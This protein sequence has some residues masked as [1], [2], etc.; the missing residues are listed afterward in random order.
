MFQGNYARINS[1]AQ[2]FYKHTIVLISF[3]VFNLK[4]ELE[5][6]NNILEFPLEGYF[7]FL[8]RTLVVNRYHEKSIENISQV[9]SNSHFTY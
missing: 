1:F 8:R 9:I 4:N 3:C 7:V 5:I 2:H 6:E